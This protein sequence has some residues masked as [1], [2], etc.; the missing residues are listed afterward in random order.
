MSMLFIRR[1]LHN[2]ILIGKFMN[3]F[4]MIKKRLVSIL[5]STIFIFFMVTVQAAGDEESWS[6]WVRELRVQAISQGI[7]PNLFDHVFSTIPGPSEKVLSLYR[8]Q[9][10]KRLTFWEYRSTRANAQRIEK[11]HQEFEK[12]RVLVD[13]IGEAYGVDPC[14]I[15]ALWGLETDYGTFMGNFSVIQSLATLA[16]GSQRKAFFRGELLLAL[17]ILQERQISLEDFKGE[18]AGAS[19]YPQ[20]MPSS[21]FKYAVD[22]EGNGHKDI[23]HSLPDGLASIAN[24][25]AKNGWR[26][27]EPW[28]ME[29]TLPANFDSNLLGKQVVKSVSEW[30]NL[31]VRTQTTWP[32]EDLPAS[33]IQ[34]STG[35]ALMIF[36]N[37]RALQTW[38]GSSYYVPMVGYLADHICSGVK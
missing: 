7:D 14:V 1:P 17:K 16:Y 19:G 28:S 29:V 22:Y 20:F 6:E 21:W 4:L 33:I 37:F 35:P 31:G 30:R 3:R 32:R 9:P 38:N 5:L 36:N 13:K 18:W 25:L 10:E 34:I 2:L 15:I 27:G 12:H 11:G 26:R 8:T 23:W 24:Y